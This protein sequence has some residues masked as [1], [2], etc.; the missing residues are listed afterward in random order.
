MK[1]ICF[2]PLILLFTLFTLPFNA[3]RAE[4]ADT[5]GTDNAFYKNKDLLGREVLLPKEPS[6]I[7]SLA[8]SNTEIVFALGAGSRL[9][10]DTSF[11][12]FPPEAKK[13]EHIGDITNPNLEQIIR[14]SPELVL[15]GNKLSADTIAI[16]E[17]MKI[18]VAITEGTSINEVYNSILEI[19]KMT[20]KKDEAT[21]LVQ[22]MEKK[23]AE[24]TARV[25]D[26][27]RKRCYYIVSFGDYGN[28][29]CGP[30]SFLHE[31]IELAGGDNT[32]AVIG[33]PWGLFQM[34]KLIALDPEILLAGKY[35]GPMAQLK[36]EPGFRE[37]N[38]VK[39]GRIAVLD[40]D[41]TGRPGPRLVL[42]LEQIATVLHPEVFAQGTAK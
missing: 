28:W 3:C 33:K 13:L 31:M 37:L 22:S 6:R 24:I 14:L 41:L 2:I 34:E 39:S 9:V 20:G 19:G 7:I 38:S 32:G 12:D 36:D 11:C 42:G 5:G 18:P 4:K 8:P 10:G 15:A 21:A 25:K 16:L 30:G 35:S 40:D 1:R 27:P 17:N 29:T 26:S 23:V